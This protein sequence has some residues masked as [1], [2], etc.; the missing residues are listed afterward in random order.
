MTGTGSYWVNDMSGAGITINVTGTDAITT[1]GQLS[2]T[3]AGTELK[4]EGKNKD[5]KILNPRLFFKLTKSKLNKTDKAKLERKMKNLAAHVK[6]LKEC[7]QQAAF[8]EMAKY[9]TVTVRELEAQS[10]GVDRW[11]DIKQI[12]KF[13]KYQNLADH[14]FFKEVKDFP[15]VMPK[16]VRNK[17]KKFQNAGIFDK[18][19]VLYLDYSD[20]RHEKKKTNKEKIREKDPILFGQFDFIKN[21]YYYITD[22][23]DEYC[24]LTLEAFVDEYRELEGDDGVKDD[25]YDPADVAKVD[26]K[27][28]SDIMQ[29]VRDQHDRLEKTKPSNYRGLMVEEDKAM[30]NKKP[31]WKFWQ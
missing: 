20:E 15:R 22:W 3:E 28:V 10:L 25:L 11:I 8:E 9:L 27:F 6:T 2:H 24:D 16:V 21:R 1:T 18:L 13:K 17:V 7:G 23:V 14:V 5:G 12:N 19:W 29:M 31:W 26:E 30:K 4:L